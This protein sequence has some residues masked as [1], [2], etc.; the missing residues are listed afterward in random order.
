[1]FRVLETA[2]P[3]PEPSSPPRLLII[4][5]GLM[6]ALGAGVAAGLLLEVVDSSVH[7]SRE[8]QGAF[9][10]PVLASIPKVMLEWDRARARRRRFLAIA[11]GLSLTAVTLLGAGAG[12]WIV[13]GPERAPAN[14]GREAGGTARAPSPQG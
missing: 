6:L 4:A 7:G 13:N 10:M 2:F 12:Y 5:L 11:F 3:P 9:G 14:A 8:A 1:Q